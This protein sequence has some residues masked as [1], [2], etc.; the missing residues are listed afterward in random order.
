MNSAG[1]ADGCLGFD[2]GYAPLVGLESE[3]LLLPL[4]LRR[5][6][7]IGGLVGVCEGLFIGLCFWVN[8]SSMGG[9]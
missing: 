4:A 8:R 3:R 1:K 5:R 7:I 9:F 2:M 6:F